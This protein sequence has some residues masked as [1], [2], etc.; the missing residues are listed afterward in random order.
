MI[1]TLVLFETIA[2]AQAI[3]LPKLDGVT[4]FGEVGDFEG[5]EVVDSRTYGPIGAFGWGFET[6]FTVTAKDDYL[7]EI[8]VG[9]DQLFQRGKLRDFAWT[10][11]V[12]DL[13]STA[14]YVSFPD[15]L[16]VGLAT[17]IASLA[18]ASI[19]DGTSRYSVS[20]DTFDAAGIIGFSFSFEDRPLDDRR[21]GGFVEL[22]YHA[23]YFGGVDYGPGAPASLPG[24]LYLGGFVASAGV[25]IAIGAKAALGKSKPAAPSTPALAPAKP[26]KKS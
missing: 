14:I 4:F 8:G 25:Q 9:Y 21:V 26:A 2:A 6:A 3:P 15:G 11:E 1:S 7:V 12:R 5:K 10:G 24:S 19:D 22:A 23:R 13:P 18:N 16:Y 17:G 20:G